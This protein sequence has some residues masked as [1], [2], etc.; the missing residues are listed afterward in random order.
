MVNFLKI[1][2]YSF[3]SKDF[4][5]DIFNNL[6]GLQLKYLLLI[7]A[8]TVLPININ[9][10]IELNSIYI[11]TYS[12]SSDICIDMHPES[13]DTH[14]ESSD[15][16]MFTHPESSDIHMFIHPESSDIHMFMHPESS[17]MCLESSQGLYNYY[18]STSFLSSNKGSY[19]ADIDEDSINDSMYSDVI[20]EETINSVR[21]EINNPRNENGFISYGS[22]ILT[23]ICVKNPDNRNRI[24]DYILC[25]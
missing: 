3:Y 9:Q 22:R 2:Q 14:P 16:H 25:R 21:Y 7:V 20:D 6:R 8:I 24:Y 10:N 11:D 5:K 13:Y 18:T 4:Y 19:S 15:I 23:D 17:D 1:V 12:D